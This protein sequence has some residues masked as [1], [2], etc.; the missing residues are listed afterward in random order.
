MDMV[1]SQLLK[2]SLG[3][4]RQNNAWT[5]PPPGLYAVDKNIDVWGNLLTQDSNDN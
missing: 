4:I 5:L 3:M 1:L 2:V